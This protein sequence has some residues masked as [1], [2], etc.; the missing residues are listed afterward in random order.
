MEKLREVLETTL[1]HP[2]RFMCPYISSDTAKTLTTRAVSNQTNACFI[3]VISYGLVSTLVSARA[4]SA[5]S[6]ALS[7]PSTLA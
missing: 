3:L 4:W 2:E 7:G 5:C 1:I 6:S